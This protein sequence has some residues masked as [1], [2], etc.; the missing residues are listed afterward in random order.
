MSRSMSN[1]ASMRLTASSDRR[2]HGCVPAASEL[3]A[4]SAN[5]KNSLRAC[6]QQEAGVIVASALKPP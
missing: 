6:A 4:M 5:S 2:D 1:K 3:V